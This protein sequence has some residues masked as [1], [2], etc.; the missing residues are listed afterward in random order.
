MSWQF[1]SC[2]SWVAKKIDV[3]G[4]LSPLFFL[5]CGLGSAGVPPLAGFLFTSS[6][7]PRSVPY[8]ALI[9]VAVITALWTA[10]WLASRKKRLPAG[11]AAAAETF[12]LKR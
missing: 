11:G 1:G 10:M 3:T 8:L 9:M 5:G 4:R 6:W 12:E 7:G 2:Y